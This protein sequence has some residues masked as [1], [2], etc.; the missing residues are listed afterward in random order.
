MR[1]TLERA[2]ARPLRELKFLEPK[3]NQ[4]PLCSTYEIG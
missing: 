4:R 2:E 3:G 1:I